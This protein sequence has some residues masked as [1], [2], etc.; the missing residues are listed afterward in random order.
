M[1]AVAIRRYPVANEG[2]TTEIGTANE[3]AIALDV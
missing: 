2:E 3:L 1:S